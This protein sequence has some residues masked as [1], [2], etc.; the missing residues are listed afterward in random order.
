M[1]ITNIS[2][3]LTKAVMPLMFAVGDNTDKKIDFNLKKILLLS[4]LSI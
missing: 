3:T 4:F 2:L 1:F